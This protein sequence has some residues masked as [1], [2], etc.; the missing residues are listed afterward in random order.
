LAPTAGCMR[1]AARP[2]WY[3]KGRRAE[4]AAQSLVSRLHRLT[5]TETANRADPNTRLQTATLG[6]GM[7]MSPCLDF[8][9]ASLLRLPIVSE[10]HG[11][12]SG[13]GPFSFSNNGIPKYADVGNLDFDGVPHTNRADT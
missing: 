5:Q 11:R 3:S 1:T 6:V 9:C 13:R 8:T 7:P 12:L 10:D 2:A 4:T